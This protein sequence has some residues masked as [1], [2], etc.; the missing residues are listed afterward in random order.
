MVIDRPFLEYK[1]KE[2]ARR[3]CKIRKDILIDF[4]S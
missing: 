3:D 2:K 1:P 4:R